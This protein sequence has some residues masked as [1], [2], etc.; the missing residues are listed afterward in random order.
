MTDPTAELFARLPERERD[1]VRTVLRRR[2]FDAGTVVCHEGDPGDSCHFVVDGRFSVSVATALGDRAVLAIHGPGE[3]F[4]ELALFLDEGTRTAT[5]TALEASTTL[6]LHRHEFD[7]VSRQ[8][9]AVLRFF[10]VL[11]AE[12]T[13]R[14]SHAALSGLFDPVDKRVYAQLC[15]LADLYLGDAPQGAV[16]V[17]Q[18]IVAGLAGTTRPTVN[19]VLKQAEH[20]G[21]VELRRGQIDVLD[22]DTLRRRAR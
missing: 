3:V 4:G 7:D 13:V 16:P 18:E 15:L 1:R 14:L 10:V 20:D 8:Y 22:R 19:R 11:L 5:I 2:R 6:E 12:R 17:R 9:P 21:L